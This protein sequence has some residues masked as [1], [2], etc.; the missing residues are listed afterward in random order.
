MRVSKSG[1]YE[2]PC[3]QRIETGVPTLQ[4]RH[5]ALSLSAITC[6]WHSI[7]LLTLLYTGDGLVANKSPGSSY[8]GR[9]VLA[10]RTVDHPTEVIV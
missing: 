10:D 6:G 9:R 1:Q 4:V 8:S 7:G 3:V 2:R 5:I